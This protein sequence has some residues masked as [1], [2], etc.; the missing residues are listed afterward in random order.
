MIFLVAQNGGFTGFDQIP[1]HFE[2]VTLGR[3]VGGDGERELVYLTEM[4]NNK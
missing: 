3:A 2:S 4:P 1:S